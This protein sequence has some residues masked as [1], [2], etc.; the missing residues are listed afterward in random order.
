MY[1]LLTYGIWYFTYFEF[2]KEAALFMSLH[3]WRLNLPMY[4]L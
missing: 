3:L 4:H 1:F 2:E